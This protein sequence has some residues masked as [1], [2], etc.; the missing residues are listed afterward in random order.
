MW[1]MRSQEFLCGLANWSSALI[2][3]YHTGFVNGIGLAEVIGLRYFCVGV[4]FAC[5]ILTDGR[6]PKCSN[7]I[8]MEPLL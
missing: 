1:L 8:S 4:M 5:E 2:F 7:L 6:I 3:L